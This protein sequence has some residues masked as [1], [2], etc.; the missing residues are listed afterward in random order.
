MLSLPR[1]RGFCE[2]KFVFCSKFGKICGMAANPYMAFYAVA[3]A[4]GPVE[5]SWS[6]DRGEKGQALASLNVV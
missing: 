4:S 6:D 5:V 1:K 3:E 2:S